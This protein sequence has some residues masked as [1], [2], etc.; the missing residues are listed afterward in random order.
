MKSAIGADIRDVQNR[1]PVGPPLVDGLGDGLYE[2]RTKHDKNDYR[3]FFCF[4]GRGR[5]C[6]FQA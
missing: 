6:V 1:W 2:V 4:V 3:M 5:G